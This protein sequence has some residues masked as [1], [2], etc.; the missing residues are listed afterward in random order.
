MKKLVYICTFVLPLTFAIS[1]DAQAQSTKK[2]ETKTTKSHKGKDA[3]IGGGVGAVTGAVVSHKHGKG[4]VVGG[5][6]G[7]GAGY[8]YG[9]H[10]DKKAAAH[11]KHD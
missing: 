10:K 7:A 8:L 9:R 11:K 6:V 5:L 1:N 3:A 2:E 4:A